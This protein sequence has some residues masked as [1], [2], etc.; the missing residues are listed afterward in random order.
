MEKRVWGELP[1]LAILC[2]PVLHA[3]SSKSGP[4]KLLPQEQDP[5]SQHQAAGALNCV[6]EH[7]C[8]ISI[9]FVHLLAGCFLILYHTKHVSELL[10]GNEEPLGLRHCPHWAPGKASYV[11]PLGL[12]WK[13]CVWPGL[14][15]LFS[16]PGALGP[17]LSPGKQLQPRGWEHGLH[18]EPGMQDCPVH[19]SPPAHVCG[20]PSLPL[21]L[22]QTHSLR[23]IL[24]VLPNILATRSIIQYI[25]AFSF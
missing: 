7:L 17:H 21:S 16:D 20:I 6:R 10:M 24:S 12:P 13:S 19:P 11:M 25:N 23:F 15:L 9:Y 1:Y 14:C 4:A 2:V 8:F 22:A 3:L 18:R 5:A